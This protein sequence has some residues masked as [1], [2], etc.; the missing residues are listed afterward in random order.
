M[1]SVFTLKLN[2]QRMKVNAQR[3]NVLFKE[4][5][6]DTPVGFPIKGGAP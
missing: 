6:I 1:L 5:A 4:V 3:K 2:A